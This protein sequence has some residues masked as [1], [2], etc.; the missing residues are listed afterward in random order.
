MLLR[1]LESTVDG[2]RAKGYSAFTAPPVECPQPTFFLRTNTVHPKNSGQGP[3]GPVPRVTSPDAFLLHVAVTTDSQ[4]AR[5]FGGS[6]MRRG[7]EEI[8][9][10]GDNCAEITS[11]IYSDAAGLQDPARREQL[12]LTGLGILGP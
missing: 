4:L 6:S 9:C 10:S 8:T 2:L 1:L 7:A 3:V 12:L 11:A 5:I